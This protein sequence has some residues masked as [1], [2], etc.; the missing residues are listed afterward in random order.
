M[1]SL[2]QVLQWGNFDVPITIGICTSSEK[3]EELI[4]K[5]CKNIVFVGN[6][7]FKDK[8]NNDGEPYDYWFKE[9]KVDT[10]I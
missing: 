6:N 10:L 3:A 8:H 9:I 5:K 4:K 1:E 7:K 2:Y